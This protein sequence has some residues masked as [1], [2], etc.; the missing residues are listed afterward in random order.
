MRDLYLSCFH[1]VDL[2][3]EKSFW[4][5]R[6]E[7][8]V[9]H[10]ILDSLSWCGVCVTCS[11]MPESS[12]FHSFFVFRKLAFPQ[13][14]LLWFQQAWR[15]KGQTLVWQPLRESQSSFIAHQTSPSL[16]AAAWHRCCSPHR[17]AS[18]ASE[19]PFLGSGFLP[20]PVLWAKWKE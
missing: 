14:E 18:S 5:P 10:T 8:C 7:I 2:T 15:Y 20:G 16:L 13:E 19:M 11:S 6:R 1:K 3:E 12:V 9:L 17:R 4:K